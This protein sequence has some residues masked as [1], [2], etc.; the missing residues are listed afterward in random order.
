MSYHDQQPK[1]LQDASYPSELAK[2][3]TT[4]WIV[5]FG[6]RS[7]TGRVRSYTANDYSRYRLPLTRQHSGDPGHQARVLILCTRL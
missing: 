3:I 7:S 6:A 1:L 4:G 2:T 5:N